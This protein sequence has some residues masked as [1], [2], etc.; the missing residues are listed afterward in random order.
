MFTEIPRPEVIRALILAE[1]LKYDAP[2]RGALIQSALAVMVTPE[3]R[4]LM[5]NPRGNGRAESQL[6]NAVYRGFRVLRSNGLVSTSGGGVYELTDAGRD[7][8]KTA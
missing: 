8:A 5:Q 7:A 6:Q 1:M 2:V 4:A 3:V